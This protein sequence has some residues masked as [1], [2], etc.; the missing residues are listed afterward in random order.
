MGPLA[1]LACLAELNLNSCYRVS[2]LGPLAKLDRLTELNLGGCYGVSDLGPLANLAR[3]T[4]LDFRYCDRVSDL[5]PLA[6]LAR[7]TTLDLHVGERV[8]DLGPLANL[9]RLTTLDL[10]NCDRVSDLGPLANLARLTT[11]NLSSCYGVSDL[12]PLANLARLTT[13]DLSNCDRVSDLGPLAKLPRLTTLRLNSTGATSFGRL[14]DTL[15]ELKNLYL[16]GTRFHDVHPSVC[17]ERS[18]DNCLESVRQ[19][20]DA[21]GPDAKPDAE[22]RLFV[23]GNGGAGKSYFVRRLQGKTFDGIEREKLR[24]THGVQI[25]TYRTPHKDWGLPHPVRLGIWDFGGQDIY[26]STHALFLREPAVYALLF[27]HTTENDEIVREGGFEMQ[28]RRLSYWFAYLRQEAG[29]SGTVHSPVLLVQS[30]DDEAPAWEE[31]NAAPP[32]RQFPQVSRIIRASSKAPY[33]LDH[34][35]FTLKCAVEKLL[36]D[37]PQPPLP[38][39][40]VKVRDA[41]RVRPGKKKQPT[42]TQEEFQTICKRHGCEANAVV[43]RDALHQMGVVFYRDGIFGDRIVVD[44]AWVLE[45]VYAIFDRTKGEAFR[46]EVSDKRRRFR[47]S[48]LERFFWPKEEESQTDQRTYLS[49]ME[50]CGICFR[51]DPEGQASYPYDGLYIAPDLLPRW[52]D[53]PLTQYAWWPRPPDAGVTVPYTVLHDGI[54]RGFLSSIGRVAGD[55]AEY[56]RYGCWLRDAATKSEALVRTQGNAIRLEARDGDAAKLLETLVKMLAKV[57]CGQPLRVVWDDRGP[58]AVAP[59]R[60]GGGKPEERLKPERPPPEEGG[61]VR[62]GVAHRHLCE[63]LGFYLIGCGLLG[64]R[65]KSVNKV[66]GYLEELSASQCPEDLHGFH[67]STLWKY[68]GVLE[69]KVFTQYFRVKQVTLLDRGE[70]DGSPGGVPAVL[71]DDGRR[72]WKATRA[73]LQAEGKLPHWPE[74]LDEFV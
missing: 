17:G 1:K 6:N 32:A 66:F 73:F 48:D 34:F 62:L 60:P 58:N 20:L 9:A 2:D 12:G 22:I 46:Q 69:T 51:A 29:S 13:L 4:T 72:A 59:E 5:G 68:V 70:N 63:L 53:G 44:Q 11:L 39:S 67:K 3:L 28:N 21:C 15:P 27:S 71:T 47:R 14:H 42:L 7:L 37:H 19:Y 8:S 55:R 31:P 23:L 10:S 33:G 41:V 74:P 38:A 50:Q 24:S 36:R 45:K 26:H 57:P 35:L 61:L 30:R 64:K 40:W 52:E 25:T 54:A 65:Y 49:F 56:W 16:Y 43:L 18:S